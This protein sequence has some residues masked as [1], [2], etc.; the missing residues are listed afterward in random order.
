MGGEVLQKLNDFE[1]RFC[2]APMC[3][4]FSNRNERNFLLRIK[5]FLS[6]GERIW[7]SNAFRQGIIATI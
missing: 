7:Q 1:R 2:P 6:N 5:T 4:G 3:V